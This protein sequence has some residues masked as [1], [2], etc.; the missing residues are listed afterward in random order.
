MI[1]AF[2][3][4]D[5]DALKS[6]IRRYPLIFSALSIVSIAANLAQHYN[7][8]VMRETLTRR[9]RLRVFGKILSFEPAYFDEEANSIGAV[10]AR[11]GDEVALVKTLV[12]DQ[13]SLMIQTAAA[14]A[15]AAAAVAVAMAMALAV[16]WKLAVVMIAVQPLSFFSYYA[17]KID[18]SRLTVKVARAQDYSTQIAVEA[19]YNHHIVA[20]FGCADKLL[21]IFQKAQEE[22]KRAAVKRAWTTGMVMDC[23]PC[24][25]FLSWALDFWYGGKLA[26][27][28]E[29][30][31]GDV[32]KT[33]F[34][35]TKLVY[36][37]CIL[38]KVLHAA[39]LLHIYYALC[40]ISL[41]IF[42][43]YAKKIILSRLTVKVARAQDHN[44][45]IGIEVVYNHNIVA[46]FGCVDKLLGIF[47]K[48]QEEPKR[49]AVK[50]AWITGMAMGC[51]PC[52][53]FL[54]WALDF[55]YGGKLAENGE[56]SVGDVFKTFFIL[57]S[58]SKMALY[59]RPV[60]SRCY[61]I[62]FRNICDTFMEIIN[63]EVK[64]MLRIC[65]IRDNISF[66]K[67]DASEDEIVEAAR[68]ANAHDFISTLKEGYG[69]D[70]GERGLQ[71]SGDQKQRIAIAR[72]ILRNPSILL[73]DEATSS[74]DVLSE[75]VVQEALQ[76]IMVGRTA[77]VVAHRLNTVKNLD[78]I[79]FVAEGKVIEQ[80]NY[81]LLTSKR[82]AF[83]NLAM[84]Q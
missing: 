82:G 19:V 20:S 67:P 44:T 41:S 78:T 57:V 59:Q 40:A 80:G 27:N 79:A 1:A 29:I 84:L 72:E 9:I 49:V 32:F 42:S 74:P 58:T 54:S 73:L 36:L 50:R 69:T 53:S 37:V 71:L 5:H 65:R 35:L 11:L 15:A 30:S 16:A 45:Q 52:L 81:T 6:A 48:A 51:S 62:T 2:F 17:K 61:V 75:R 28:G 24:L 4:P 55:W 25:S 12:A 31:A 38:E 3:L 43:Y 64:D 77:V 68:G 33:F 83:F 10:C 47:Q 76:R 60:T 34:I 22:P 39:P 14:A 66:G 8:A 26:E 63:E 23:S 46:S 56:I 70:C 18:L 21:G 7:F 13:F